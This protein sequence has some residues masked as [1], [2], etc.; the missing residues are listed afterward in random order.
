MKKQLLAL[1]LIAATI[2]TTAFAR[3]GYG[4]HGPAQGKERITVTI[5]MDAGVVHR[6]Q[7]VIGLKRKLKQI[8]P[9][10][11]LTKADLK[12]VLVKAKSKAGYGTALVKEGQFYSR[13][14]TIDKSFKHQGFHKPGGFSEVI[15][16]TPREMEQVRWQLVLNGNIKVKKID[17]TMDIPAR[18]MRKAQC[19]VK[20]ETM[21]GQSWGT[22]T[23]EA[24]GQNKK[25]AKAKAC[26]KAQQQCQDKMNA[27][28]GFIPEITNI[29]SCVKQ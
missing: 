16:R 25:R 22:F 13:Q 28:A 24:K 10:L 17:V 14:K 20:L 8:R 18:K 27:L 4:G 23:A 7:T 21:F 19:S 26:K 5:P 12:K 29:V 6:Q 15:L 3:N 2:S 9:N 1:S 11:D